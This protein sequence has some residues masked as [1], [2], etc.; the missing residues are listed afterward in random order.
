MPSYTQLSAAIIAANYFAV[1]LLSSSS[2]AATAQAREPGERGGA[3]R[4]QARAFSTYQK[5]GHAHDKRDKYGQREERPPGRL[6]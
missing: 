4:E 6:P 3:L 2:T 5:T 1:I